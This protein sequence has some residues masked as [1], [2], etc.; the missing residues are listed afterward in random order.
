MKKVLVL[1]IC[2]IMLVGCQNNSGEN[3]NNTLEE[4][5]VEDNQSAVNA[6]EE[7]DAGGTEVVERKSDFVDSLNRTVTIEEK[8]L[9]VVSLYASFA[10]LW[11]EA[12]GELVGIIESSS[13]PEKAIDLPKLGKMSTPNVEAILALEPDLVIIRAGYAKQEELIDTFEASNINVFAVDYNNFDETMTAYE[14]FCLMN[15]REDLYETKA[16]PMIEAVESYKSENEF[17]YLLMFATSKSISTKDDNITSH[18]IDDL[19]GMNITSEYQIADEETKQFSFEKILEANP[20]YIFVQTMGTVE[21]AI[22]RMDSDI[23]SNPAWA[24]LDAVKEGR[25]F[26][27]PKELFIYKPNMRFVEAYDY[28]IDLLGK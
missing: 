12:G 8:P 19:G 14:N 22:A 1:I 15:E 24:S 3:T 13:I 10:D 27:L 18:I 26:Y 20:K 17:S 6:S 2:M 4:A 21:D 23:T 25:F 9:K 16:L 5:S 7:S 28:I 11:Y